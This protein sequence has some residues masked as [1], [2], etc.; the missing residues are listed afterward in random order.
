MN[1]FD[2]K[3]IFIS[4]YT[5]TSD[6]FKEKFLLEN[7]TC[8]FLGFIDKVQ[9]GNNIN[10]IKDIKSLDFDFILII[11]PNHFESIYSDYKTIISL[12]KLI[13][14]NINNN[15]YKYLFQKDI[16]NEK[17]VHFLKRIKERTLKLSANFLDLISYK[18]ENFTFISKNFI[19]GNNKFLFLYAQENSIKSLMLTNNEEQYEELKN[20]GF[21][22]YLL[23]S[24]LAYFYLAISK[25]VIVDQGDNSSLLNHLS[26]RQKIV[27]QWHGVPLEHMNLLVDIQ[28]DYFISTSEY[29]S[30]TSFSYVFL[31]KEFISCG[32][33]RNDV[34]LKK[35]HTPS[36]LIFTDKDVYSLAKNKYGTKEKIIVYMP[37]FRESD[38]GKQDSQFN[39]LAL[40]F[41]SLNEELKK[42]DTYMIIK[43]HPFVMIFYKDLI[44]ESTY[45]N[46]FF[47]NIQGDIYPILKY[48]DILITDYSSVYADYLLL[49]RPIIFYLYDHENCSKMA[50]GYLYEFDEVSPG[51][52]AY[53]QEELIKIISKINN[54]NDKF[55]N[56][57][58][59]LQ[60]KFF[61]NN[62]E[63]SAERVMKVLNK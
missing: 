27:Q 33:A 31:S 13:K 28:Y 53:T 16:Y 8:N 36:D 7:N 52:K 56:R 34:F 14:I 43:L 39:K 37:T 62:D 12:S 63:Y 58:I 50:H 10:K 2:N 32:Y 47:H 26:S 19:T 38:F 29:V 40:E 44:N 49:N 24:F 30:N 60:N 15:T 35:D 23:N 3:K 20:L 21:R 1:M 5:K 45:S 51:E 46:I 41:V 25:F 9:T 48:T 59:E 22:V 55:S 57:R 17:K 6:A 54:G 61:S 4:P 42:I 11:S 18:R